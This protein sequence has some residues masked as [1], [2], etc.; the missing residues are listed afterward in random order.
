[1]PKSLANE[2][3][4]S[5]IVK[6]SGAAS[7][8]DIPVRLI[9]DQQKGEEQQQGTSTG[10]EVVSLTEAIRVSVDLD[11]DLIGLALQQEIPVLKV[12]CLK[13]LA[14]Q[15]SRKTQ[16]SKKGNILPEK[17][18]RFKTGIDDND[19]QRKIDNMASFLDKGHNCMVSIR[20]TRR[21]MLKDPDTARNTANQIME[22]V[23]DVGELEGKLKV[24]PNKTFARFL[25]RPIRTRKNKDA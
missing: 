23:G 16:S 25:L 20:S 5:A 15:Q 24:N 17:E 22:L 13:R 10:V 4:V 8:D 11:Q 21:Q 6:K 3:L 19:L 18:F 2:R 14:Y 12:D 1:M 9:V 7:A